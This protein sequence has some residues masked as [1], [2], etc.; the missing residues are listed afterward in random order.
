MRKLFFTA[1]ALLLTFGAAHAQDAPVLPAV[2]Q[3]AADPS[4][5]R[6][7][8]D[9]VQA[10]RTLF[11]KRRNGGTVYTSAGG[12]VL[13]R[14]ILSGPYALGLGASAVVSAPLLGVGISKLVRFGSKRENE[15][16]KQYQQGKPLPPAIRRRL[17]P[18]Y[19]APPR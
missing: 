9:S 12:L 15:V 14:G 3:P 4:L 6:P 10:V 2:P 18:E 19:F 16:I 5:V 7:G 1:A 17:R 13:L 11:R 8:T